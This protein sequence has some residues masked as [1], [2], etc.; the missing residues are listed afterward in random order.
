[1]ADPID[2]ADEKRAEANR[3]YWEDSRPVDEVA[4]AL[5]MSRSALYAAIVPHPADAA[6][7]TCGGDAVYPNRRHRSHGVVRCTSCGAEEAL[8]A[9]NGLDDDVFDSVLAGTPRTVRGPGGGL[10][11]WKR[12]LAEVDW[13]RKGLIGGGAA[14]GLLAGLAVGAAF[15]RR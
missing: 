5:G 9:G 6:C 2:L 4:A 3:L 1:M 7:A 10:D 8:E 15:R 12:D 14:L 13:S 11:E